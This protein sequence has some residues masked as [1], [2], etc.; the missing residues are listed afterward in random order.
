MGKKD[1]STNDRNYSKKASGVI[2]WILI[3]GIILVILL[4]G[5]FLYK[6]Y[7]DFDDSVAR[8]FSVEK[9]S[10]GSEF[11]VQYHVNLN[12]NQKYYLFEDAVPSDFEILDCEYDLNNKIKF[13]EIQN[14]QSRVFECSIKASSQ[15]G[16]YTFKGEYSLSNMENPSM[17][18]GNKRILV[19]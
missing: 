5:F 17:I 6:F 13:I 11:K 12:Q 15:T 8:V 19:E 1:F 3:I 18:K 10:P 9:V 14:A 16:S 4:I 2:L 7:Y